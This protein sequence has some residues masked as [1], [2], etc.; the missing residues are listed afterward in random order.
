MKWIFC[1][2]KAFINL[3]LI[4]SAVCLKENLILCPSLSV[5]IV[6]FSETDVMLI[7]IMLC[8]IVVP[9]PFNV[10]TYINYVSLFPVHR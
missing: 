2:F 7:H 6:S 8:L 4:L 1:K 9:F 3:I 10:M 5:V